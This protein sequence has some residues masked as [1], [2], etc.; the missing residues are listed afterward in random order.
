MAD[1]LPKTGTTMS[2]VC[3]PVKFTCCRQ[4][5]LD[6]AVFVVQEEEYLLVGR[7]CWWDIYSSGLA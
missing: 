4:C 1:L 2:G 6:D 3:V 7:D 5:A